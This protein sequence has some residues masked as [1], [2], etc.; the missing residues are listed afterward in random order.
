MML[1]TI[2]GSMT[3]RYFFHL[4]ADGRI[5]SDPLGVEVGTSADAEAA[6]LEAI[7]E[8][9][10]EEPNRELELRGWSM[11]VTDAR[12]EIVVLLPIFGR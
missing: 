5:L 3:S 1:G 10:M 9:R 11:A 2:P 6:A 8:F 12:G 4:I 7:D